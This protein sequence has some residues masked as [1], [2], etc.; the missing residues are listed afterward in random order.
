LRFQLF[1]GEFYQEE[2][3]DEEDHENYGKDVKVPVYKR[4]YRRAEF[5]Y[6]SRYQ[7]KPEAPSDYGSYKEQR[8]L[9]PEKPG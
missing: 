2:A 5:P 6:Q 8:E 9:E 4:F 1:K 3:P 7:E